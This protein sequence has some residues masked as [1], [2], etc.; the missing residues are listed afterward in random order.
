VNRPPIL[1]A[2]G[3]RQ[4]NEGE[5]LDFDV[6]AYDPDG[7]GLG[8]SGGDLPPGAQLTDDGVGTAHFSWTPDYGTAGNYRVI[9]I[10][11]DDGVPAE[12][13]HEEIILT[14]GDVNRPPVLEPIGDRLLDEGESL[15]IVLS[16][17]DPDGDGMIFSANDLPDGSSFT[18]QSDGTALFSW[19]PGY[20][21]AGN[22]SVEFVVTDDGA[23]AQSDSERVI[24]SVGEVNRPPSLDPIGDRSVNEGAALSIV[25]TAN[26]PD[27]DSLSFAADSLPDGATLVDNGD[28]TA[29]FDWQPS[30]G[31]AGA[32]PVSITVTDNG[33]PNLSA[34][35]AITISVE[36]G[37]GCDVI[38]GDIDGDCDVDMDDM[39]IIMAARNTQADG[40][41]DPRDLDGDGTITANDARQLSLLC[42]R[43]R[44]T[45]E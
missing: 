30:S 13:D 11:T 40:D 7:D 34:T 44:C 22:H 8:F 16:A 29:R 15:T 6:S 9:I 43:P 2:I 38:T 39:N 23:P 28:G 10:V 25:I 5:S 37:G 4:V 27:G 26:D 19:T 14:V 12:S 18:T 41:D 24:L 45:T 1:D 17:S 36:P 20:A 21:Q 35:E 32:Y 31:Q 33:V 3:D 42:T